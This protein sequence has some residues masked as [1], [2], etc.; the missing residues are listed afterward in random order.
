[1]KF[2]SEVVALAAGVYWLFGLAFR[3]RAIPVRV[4]GRWRF[5]MPMF[6]AGA[7]TLIALAAYGM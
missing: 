6:L 7:I 4:V 1:M 3:R 2:V 5:G